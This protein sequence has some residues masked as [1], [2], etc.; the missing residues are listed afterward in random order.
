[1]DEIGNFKAKKQKVKIKYYIE[2]VFDERLESFNKRIKALDK[3]YKD[4]KIIR[5]DQEILDIINK[6]KEPICK[7]LINNDFAT[8]REYDVAFK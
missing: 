3:K 7:D 5:T 1:M 2:W 8:I 6:I 4:C